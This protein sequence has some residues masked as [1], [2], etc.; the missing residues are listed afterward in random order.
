MRKDLA[1]PRNFNR[2]FEIP[3]TSHLKNP[4]PQRMDGREPRCSSASTVSYTYQQAMKPQTQLRCDVPFLESS[5]PI[6]LASP[7]V[8]VPL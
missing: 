7:G 2:T 1:H 4:T 3:S 5:R 6:H 8:V